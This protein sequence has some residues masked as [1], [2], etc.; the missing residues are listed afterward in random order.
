[1]RARCSPLD[2]KVASNEAEM[3]GGLRTDEH[4]GEE[5]VCIIRL[6]LTRCISFTTQER[7]QV[8]TN[9]E[10]KADRSEKE[11]IL[12]MQIKVLFASLLDV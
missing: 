6:H 10:I 11:R 5:R 9:C 8:V 4:P 2:D 7:W 1:M 12:E 3:E